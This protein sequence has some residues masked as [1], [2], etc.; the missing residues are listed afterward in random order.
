MDGEVEIGPVEADRRF[1]VDRRPSSPAL[2]GLGAKTILVDVDERALPFDVLESKLLA[3]T[4]RPENVSRTALVNRLRAAGAFPVVLVTAPGGYGKTTLLAQWA[5]RDARP[6]AWVT[7]DERDNDPFV[8]LKHVAAALDRI[9]P[10]GANV[11]QAFDRAHDTIWD[12]V[13]PRLSSELSTRAASIVIVLDGVDALES[14]DSLEAI[15]ILIEKHPT[16]LDDRADR[17]G[18][19]QGA[20]RLAPRRRPLLEIG[21]YELALSRREAEILLRASGSTWTRPSSRSLSHAP[22]AGRPGCSSRIARGPTTGAR[23]A[24]AGTADV[25]SPTTCGSEYLS[26]LEPRSSASYGAPP[27]SSRCARRSATRC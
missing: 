1:G 17:A 27:C 23:P 15:G 11:L 7:V 14:T 4:G 20:D 12:A 5:E 24:S 16:R 9:E 13:A 25:T 18:P 6:F 2:R 3:P 26:R 8:L 10:L 22:R 19:P 21:H